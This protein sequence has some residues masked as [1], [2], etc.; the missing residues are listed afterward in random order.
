MLLGS[1]SWLTNDAG[2]KYNMLQ[3]NLFD[4]IM[5]NSLAVVIIRSSSTL[6]IL[7]V[8]PS[9]SV[10]VSPLLLSKYTT[11]IIK[12]DLI[13]LSRLLLGSKC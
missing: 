5:L 8:L 3:F 7:A 6:E 13:S 1:Q 9:R 10:I 2:P 12:I 11:Q 4:D